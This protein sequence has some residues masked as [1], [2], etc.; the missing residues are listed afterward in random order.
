MDF[1][2]W[3]SFSSEGSVFAAC[4]V[5]LF[6]YIWW[7]WSE[8]NIYYSWTN[9][10]PNNIHNSTLLQIQIWIIFVIFLTENSNMNIICKEYSLIY[11]FYLFLKSLLGGGYWQQQRRRRWRHGG[12]FFFWEKKKKYAISPFFDA[13]GNKKIGATLRTGREIFCLP[14]AGFFW[15]YHVKSEGRSI[16]EHPDITK[17][18]KN[19]REKLLSKL[20][21][22]SF[23]APQNCPFTPFLSTKPFF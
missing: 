10:N 12:G 5:G 14:N 21:Q 17:G 22:C 23:A 7:I 3:R 8:A 16:P 18:W 13:S 15:R 9:T 1:A 6:Y 11:I 20:R 19:L 2:Y 4:A